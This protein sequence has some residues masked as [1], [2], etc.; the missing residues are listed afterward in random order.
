MTIFTINEENNITAF[1]SQA[2][3]AASTTPCSTF[4][5]EKELAELL[6]GWPAERLVA[7]WNSL[8]GVTPVK[9]CG[10]PQSAARRIWQ[11]IQGLDAP[12]QPEQ[13]AE[14]KAHKKAKAGTQPAKGA[15]AKGRTAKK[16]TP[17]KK[18]PQ[19]KKAAKSAKSKQATG[20]REG[21]KTA[22]VIAMLQRKSGATLSEIMK[23]MG[24]QKHTVR[25]FMAGAMKKAGYPVESFKPQ[26]GER[27][28]RIHK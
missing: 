6:A 16:T 24:W 27:T 19:G 5:S 13:P 22:Q 11:R 14:P 3:A 18:A 23:T 17:A 8:P 1:A 15:P 21:S 9:S 2:E 28:Y 10:S 7:I 25:G 20:Q 12:A 4:S 26:G